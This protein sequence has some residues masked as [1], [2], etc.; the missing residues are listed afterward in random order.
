MRLIGYA[1]L[2]VDR[3]WKKSAVLFG[4]MFVIIH[5]ML[6]S[7]L[8]L[9]TTHFTIEHLFTQ[10]PNQ[11]AFQPAPG[12]QADA[13]GIT[14]E[15]MEEIKNLPYVRNARF[16]ISAFLQNS[17]GLLPYEPQSNFSPMWCPADTCHFLAEGVS[18]PLF[19][20]LEEGNIALFH[21]RTFTDEEIETGSNSAIISRDFAY[22][23]QLAIGDTLPMETRIYHPQ[24]WESTT[25]DQNDYLVR[26]EP[27]ELVII[28]LFEP[29]LSIS[30]EL[31]P[32]FLAEMNMTFFIPNRFA[33][34][35]FETASY[36]NR[37]YFTP[38]EL[39]LIPPHVLFRE[40]GTIQT[41][42][43]SLHDLRDAEAFSN[44]AWE[45]LPESYSLHSPELM[46]IAE[47]VGSMKTIQRIVSQ[48]LYGTIIASFIIIGLTGMLFCLDRKQELGIYLALGRSKG[49][50]LL[51]L[52]F[53]KLLLATP[54]AILSFFTGG[55][56][57]SWLNSWFLRTHLE[58]DV[59]TPPRSLWI[60][61]NTVTE[62]QVLSLHHI[63]MDLP[64]FA[65]IWGI[66]LAA[67]FL[68]I[69]IPA[70]YVMGLSPKKILM[71][72]K[73]G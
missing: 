47:A 9:R 53:E 33:A 22:V 72:G 6:A 29:I 25:V 67:I 58:I 48:F 61:A 11:F 46:G 23:N 14:L 19:L 38:E 24:V 13:Q 36:L 42:L 7:T 27:I 2:C 69:I 68:G 35:I 32:F 71:A 30:Q 59:A 49:H 15:A 60:I 5:L 62:E 66:A 65:I 54:I 1:F 45:L 50:V 18:E 10:S 40:S 39:A 70:F 28:G 3:N 57:A 51:Q 63:Q 64:A 34:S 44:K 56:L 55:G 52:F 4:L 12:V 17:T 21:G 73:I 16:S 41:G 8:I 43:I 31:E 37:H 20:E 26:I